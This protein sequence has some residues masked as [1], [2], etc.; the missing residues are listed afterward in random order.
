MKKRVI[1]IVISFLLL[2]CVIYFSDASRVISTISKASLSII[3]LIFLVWFVGIFLR[4]GRWWYLLKKSGI[5]VPFLQLVKIFIPSLFLSNITPGK[6]GEPIRSFLLRQT[7]NVSIG[8]SISSI[9]FERIMDIFVLIFL[10]AISIPILIMKFPNLFSWFILAIVIYLVGIGL[11]IFIISSKV[12]TKK[13]I[14][15]FY[16]IFSFIPLVK[17]SKEKLDSFAINI[18][19]SFLKFG[20]IKMLLI[21]FFY[22]LLI[23]VLE[24]VVFYLAFLSI[25][26]RISI[27]ITLTIMATATLIGV[28]SFLPGGIGSAELVFILFFT[29]QFSLTPSQVTSAALIGRIPFLMYAIAGAVILNLLKYKYKIL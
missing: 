9:L 17:K 6:I 13:F 26:L 15:I 22:T 3:S 8:R 5:V 1:S 7:N 19:E 12:R 2:G 4:T 23:W 28:L 18:S 11:V 21:T 27:L 20:T 29:T 25:G 10:A 16:S 24:G 14:T